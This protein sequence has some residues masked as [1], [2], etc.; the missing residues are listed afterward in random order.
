MFNAEGKYSLQRDRD[1]EYEWM[2]VDRAGLPH[3]ELTEFARRLKRRLSPSSVSVYLYELTGFFTWLETDP[4]CRAKGWSLSLSDSEV[5]FVI[6]QYLYVEAK[7]QVIERPDQTGTKVRYIRQ[8]SKSSLNLGAFLAVIRL[9]FDYRNCD[10]DGRSNPLIIPDFERLK[11]RAQEAERESFS[12]RHGRPPMPTVSGVDRR[13]QFRLSANYFRI[14]DGEWV[15]QT[16]DDADF[17]GRVLIAGEKAGWT[18]RETALFRLLLES[19]A[20]PF[21]ILELRIRDWAIHRFG[22]LFDCTNK[23][24]SLRRVKQ[25]ACSQNT[26][27]ILLRYFDDAASSRGRYAISGLRFNGLQKAF[28]DVGLSA[29]KL[30]DDIADQPI[31]LAAHGGTLGVATIRRLYWQPALAAAGIRANPYQCRH[32]FVTNAMGSI[33]ELSQSDAQYQYERKKLIKYMHWKRPG[34]IEA[35]EH[36]TRREQFISETL[37]RIHEEMNKRTAQASSPRNGSA[38]QGVAAARE[39]EKAQKELDYLLGR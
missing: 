23:G 33:K 8:T 37:P 34:T 13:S 20:R 15:P 19:G 26:L 7:C 2:V 5:R 35:Y 12:K 28:L 30:P 27:K 10:K 32:W 22:S 6:E 3:A 18:L 4:V 11:K 36:S 38:R 24:A 39:F 14:R 17:F 31:F 25:I 16:I 9:Y 29:K 21:E 1:Y